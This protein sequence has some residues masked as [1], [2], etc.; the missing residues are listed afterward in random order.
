MIDENLG[1]HL[2]IIEEVSVKAAK[3]FKLEKDLIAMKMEWKDIA[4][5]LFPYKST[6]VLKGIDVIQT[7]LDDH[8]MTTQSM[9][10]SQFMKGKLR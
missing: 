7:K 5:E 8:T 6:H 4:F 10:G 1:K 2:E 9:L 3:K